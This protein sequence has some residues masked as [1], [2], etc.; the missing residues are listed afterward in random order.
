MIY[1]VQMR[2][3]SDEL[4]ALNLTAIAIQHDEIE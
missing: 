4:R 1:A 3:K 2:G